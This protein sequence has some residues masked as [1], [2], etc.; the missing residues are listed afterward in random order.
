MSAPSS[1][2]LSAVVPRPT[3]FRATTVFSAA[4]DFK[5]TSFDCWQDRVVVGCN[6]GSLR[7][8]APS[9]SPQRPEFV[10]VFT[11]SGFA[12]RPVDSLIIIEPLDVIV[13]ISDSVC[14]IH[15]LTSF[16][17]FGPLDTEGS[18]CTSIAVNDSCRMGINAKEKHP[19]LVAV[20]SR[21]RLHVFQWKGARLRFQMVKGFNI[22][23][24]VTAVDFIHDTTLCLAF[25]NHYDILHLD[26]GQ[27]QELFS[28]PAFPAESLIAVPASL[29][30]RS[31]PNRYQCCTSEVITNNKVVAAKVAVSHINGARLFTVSANSLASPLTSTTLIAVDK[32]ISGLLFTS[33]YL[34]VMTQDRIYPFNT[35]LE[36]GLAESVAFS[37]GFA[38]RAKSNQF[39]FV[40][41]ATSVLFL[42]RLSIE[43][44]VS[45]MCALKRFDAALIM[46]KES[47]GA[48]EFPSIDNV[49]LRLR[50]VNGLFAKHLFDEQM[51]PAALKRF[52]QSD[53][54]PCLVL[55]MY[56]E[57]DASVMNDETVSSL[58]PY[59]LHLRNAFPRQS[60]LVAAVDTRKTVELASLVDTTLLKMYLK[61]DRRLVIPFLSQS[62][63]CDIDAAEA[64]LIN[65][66][67]FD[68]VLFLFRSKGL[69][70]RALKLLYD[71]CNR[72]DSGFSGVGPTISYLRQLME[73]IANWDVVKNASKWIL[74]ADPVAAVR[75]FVDQYR[76]SSTL[77]LEKAGKR[78]NSERILEFLVEAAS[79]ESCILFLESF[80]EL[81]GNTEP[82]FHNAL[83]NFYLDYLQP[84][85]SSEMLETRLR[86]QDF[87]INSEYFDCQLLLERFS[88]DL[89][90]LPK[91]RA[92]LLHKCGR[93]EDAVRI[94]VVY[95][96]PMA[97]VQF[98][99]AHTNS[100]SQLHMMLLR[101]LLSDEPPDNC[102]LDRALELVQTHT[103]CINATEAINLF[104][105]TLPVAKL[106]H[107]FEKMV[108]QLFVSI[109]F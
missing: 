19:F 91:E 16:A 50:A 20:L 93:S 88:S 104:P 23:D 62:H 70:D 22:A 4:A 82:K 67:E 37:E 64:A 53:I 105:A 78:V 69:H 79:K 11:K 73:D 26:S 58:I 35:D 29:Y 65:V 47:S 103:S 94:L 76:R 101:V 92:I 108:T 71:L 42:H 43:E 10:A 38:F 8:F 83:A 52:Q 81:T 106:K 59:L 13:S 84:P 80:I 2:A 46:L 6:D 15:D 45:E 75:I 107:F 17:F 39:A 24:R 31:A 36:D 68:A 5:V 86:M 33:P 41:S 87:L 25:R 27:F 18:R 7:V 56:N 96:S 32:P 61:A 85:T 49:D 1:P 30:R 34:L 44:Q 55:S 60:S 102:L 99:D 66:N 14:N 77:A 109:V 21:S 48:A 95:D 90:N 98:C 57:L 9:G 97:A 28:A 12:K 51:Y 40:A 72:L 100:Q 63:S 89:T 54:D 74:E 3:A